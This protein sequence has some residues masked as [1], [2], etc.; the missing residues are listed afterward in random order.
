MRSLPRARWVLSSAATAILVCMPV[1]VLMGYWLRPASEGWNHIVQ[2]VLGQYVFNS[3]AVILGVALLCGVVGTITAWLTSS[4]EFTG[5]RVFSWG[6]A[7]PLAFP[8]YIISITYAGLLDYPG[9]VQSFVRDLFGFTSARDYWFPEI[10]SL[11]GVII[12]MSLVLY[13]YVYLIA[14]PVF[15]T[16]AGQ[17][18]DAAR[19]LGCSPLRA[20]WRVSLPLARPAIVAGCTLALMEALS[21]FG[22]VSFYGVPTFTTGIYR[23]WF[24]MGDLVAAA[25]LSVLLMVIVLVLRGV[26]AW[27]RNQMRFSNLAS[28]RP[29]SSRIE[30]K[31]TRNLLAFTA[32]AL[33]V[34]FGF[35]IPFIQLGGWALKDLNLLLNH[36]F[37]MMALR[38][39]GLALVASMVTVFVALLIRFTARIDLTGSVKNM[40][41]ITTLGYAIPGSVISVGILAPLAWV[42]HRLDDVAE[43]WF[44]WNLGLVLSGTIIALCYGYLVRFIAV[45]YNALDGGFASIPSQL[46]QTAMSLG[47]SPSRALWKV[48]LP[49]LRGSLLAAVLLCMID[50]LKE[51]PATLI[52][53]PFNFD[54]LATRTY[55]L[56]VEEQLPDAAIHALAIVA[57]GLIPVLWL[58]RMMLNSSRQKADYETPRS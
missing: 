31:G 13:P 14:R 38:S 4:F 49:L 50:I 52:L 17:L 35:I 39:L 19:T 8:T 9:P 53:R 58:N 1:C 21:D 20:F 55:E 12:V 6:L 7:L 15:D 51:L 3:F 45:A 5:R 10:M 46:E 44:N 27:Q 33:P 11:P 47:A 16:H 30:L 41:L 24:N 42:D 25:R 18:E 57:I 37:Y 29:A 48:D 32:C 43:S 28:S 54:T 22:S 2:T 26:E 23:A 56:A 36:E 34:L 40:N